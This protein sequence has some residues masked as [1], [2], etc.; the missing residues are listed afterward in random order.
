[1]RSSF[2]PDPRRFSPNARLLNDGISTSEYL[3]KHC[4]KCP[5]C[6]APGRKSEGCNHVYCYVCNCEWCWKCGN[7]FAMKYHYEWWCLTGCPLMQY[8]DPSAS[9]WV[10]R[11]K[12]L[13][14]IIILG[15]ICMI[16]STLSVLIIGLFSCLC[17]V[18]DEQ[19]ESTLFSTIIN[20][21]CTAFGCWGNVFIS[22]FTYVA[23]FLQRTGLYLHKKLLSISV[24]TAYSQSRG[25]LQ[26]K[27]EV[28][29]NDQVKVQE[30]PAEDVPVC[31]VLIQE[32]ECHEPVFTSCS[33]TYPTT[34]TRC[35]QMTGDEITR[36][37]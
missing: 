13:L 28:I 4:K 31:S 22:I 35:I 6:K 32:L 17:Q 23:K 33:L 27:Q 5:G 10:A 19:F 34:P 25:S 26:V 3:K 30:I 7:E 21:F 8:K 9:L 29:L 1:M 18:V 37:V 14:L 20:T 36:T 24:Q 11:L 16:F 12:S 15:P 2:L